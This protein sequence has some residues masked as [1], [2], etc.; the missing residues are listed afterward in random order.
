MKPN[1]SKKI[2]IIIII[3]VILI[4][5]AGV[6]F[7]FLKTDIFKSNKEMFFKYIAQIEDESLK[8][9]FEKIQTTGYE[10]KGKF[11]AEITKN[12]EKLEALKNMDNFSITYEGKVDAAN[13]KS[14]QNINLNYSNEVSVPTIYRQTNQIMGIY[15]KYLHKSKFISIEEGNDLIEGESINIP[16]ISISRNTEELKNNGNSIVTGKYISILNENLKDSNF[17]KENNNDLTSYKLTI[18]PEDLKNT[19]LQLLN[20]LISD[21]SALK[22]ITEDT[23]VAKQYINELI[24]LIENISIE[25]EDNIIIVVSE[26]NKTLNSIEIKYQ[27][28]NINIIKIKSEDEVEYGITLKSNESE[29]AQ[30]YLNIKYSGLNM[31]EK[32]E[33]TYELGLNIPYTEPKKESSDTTDGFEDIKLSMKQ[34]KEKVNF[35]IADAKSNRMLNDENAENLTYENIQKTLETKTDPSYD[36]MKLEKESDTT[37]SITF[38]D[39]KDKFTLDASGKIIKETEQNTNSSN[40]IDASND[41]VEDLTDNQ[42]NEEQNEEENKEENDENNSEKTGEYLN[43]VYKIKNTN[44][45][46]DSVEIEDLTKDNTIMLTEKDEAYNK[47]LLKTIVNRIDAVNKAA[48]KKIEATSELQNPITLLN[49]S[50]IME[51]QQN[52]SS[53]NNLSEIEIQTFNEKFKIYESTNQTGAS[54]KGLLTVIQ[55]NNIEQEENKNKIKEINFDGQ[56]YEANEQNITLVKSSIDTEKTYKVEFEV[57]E[58]TGLIYRAV[59]NVK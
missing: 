3:L 48:I 58:N 8:K 49:P 28:F 15:N 52:D 23:G 22:Y 30:Y 14:E 13:N 37:Y 33:E 18:K 39:T 59:I 6:T 24:Q 9:Y 40:P 17:S 10:D 35:L 2:I 25:N 31:M 4:G 20:I 51:I 42:E 12:G 41:E 27:E 53:T 1:K 7:A 19:I 26:K 16:P 5:G 32:V 43:Y 29:E 44:K 57:D 21:E 56:E 38:K 55:N 46:I 54:T 11:W 45:F 50:K 34:E 47:K 36:R